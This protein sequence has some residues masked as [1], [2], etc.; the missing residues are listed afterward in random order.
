MR[1]RRPD[2]GPAGTIR[3]RLNREILPP[4]RRSRRL[5]S[6]DAL[7]RRVHAVIAEPSTSEEVTLTVNA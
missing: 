1:V 6:R 5:P 4:R 2:N 7:I 3:E